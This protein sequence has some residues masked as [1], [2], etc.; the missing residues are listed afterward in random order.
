[1]F[2][3]GAIVTGLF[4]EVPRCERCGRLGDCASDCPMRNCDE[5]AGMGCVLDT[6]QRLEERGERSDNRPPGVVWYGTK[7]CPLGCRPPW[8]DEARAATP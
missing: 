7:A 6:E 5:C 8:A 4:A 1:M 2:D 3:P